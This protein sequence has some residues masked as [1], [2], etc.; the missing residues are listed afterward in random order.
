MHVWVCV[1]VWVCR[2]FTVPRVVA[3]WHISASQSCPV[4][5]WEYIFT[6]KCCLARGNLELQ[7]WSGLSKC[8]L[9][10]WM[11]SNPGGNVSLF[12]TDH[13]NTDGMFCVPTLRAVSTFYLW[14]FFLHRF[15]CI[16][17]KFEKQCF[18]ET[19]QAHSLGL[20]GF[21]MEC[22]LGAG[23]K[24]IKNVLIYLI[25]SNYQWVSS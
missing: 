7:K 10:H 11:I 5:S 18:C 24:V 1:S 21:R 23:L 6:L 16:L 8:S 19:G 14:L 22:V 3:C 2:S 15:I 20:E 4:S 17:L 25:Q 9:L 12:Q 13:S